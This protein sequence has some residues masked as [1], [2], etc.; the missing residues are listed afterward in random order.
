MTIAFGFVLSAVGGAFAAYRLV[1][2]DPNLRR[3]QSNAAAVAAPISL[4]VLV[5][6]AC[7][8]LM[9]PQVYRTCTTPED[10]LVLTVTRQRSLGGVDVIVTVQAPDGRQL[11]RSTIDTRDMWRDVDEM[12]PNVRCEPDRFVI[13][14]DW[15]DGKQHTDFV[16][17]KNNLGRRQ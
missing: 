7:L 14:P 3:P 2:G 12:Y 11:Y 10:G 16:L 6:A 15:W 13:G 1:G 8:P 4:G 17:L 9:R 5:L